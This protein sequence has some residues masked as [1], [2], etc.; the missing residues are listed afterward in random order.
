MRVHD[1]VRVATRALRAFVVW[2]FWTG[3]ARTLVTDMRN[4]MILLLSLNLLHFLV[5]ALPVGT[6]A[7]R[8]AFDFAHQGSFFVLFLA[9][10]VRFLL[11]L[12][13]NHTPRHP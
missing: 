3:I 11:D 4:V 10:V 1:V 6:G 12:F 7:F 9:L 13:A 8:R 5:H 2:F